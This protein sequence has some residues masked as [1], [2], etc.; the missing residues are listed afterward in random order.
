[1][2]KIF[3]YFSVSLTSHPQNMRSSHMTGNCFSISRFWDRPEWTMG[4]VHG[5]SLMDASGNRLRQVLLFGPNVQSK[6]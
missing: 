1:M 2:E 6:R 4:R 5:P 3:I